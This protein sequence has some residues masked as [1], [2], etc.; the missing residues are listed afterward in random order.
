M[1]QNSIIL[2]SIIVV[3]LIGVPVLISKKFGMKPMELL[4]GKM[5]NRG[6]F[7]SKKD[8][9]QQSDK[10]KERKQTNSNRNDMLD[11]ISR[12]ATYARRNHFRLIIPGTLSCNGEM[13]VLTALIITRCGV[14]GI[15]CFGFGGRVVAEG[16][17]KD[18]VQIMNGTQTAFP[19]PVT[20]NR[21]QEAL[22]RRV[23]EA[24]GYP[25]AEVEVVGVFTSPSVWLSNTA[26][27]N[28]YTKEEAMKV[29]RGDAYLR[30][31]GLDPRAL[32]AVLQ[33][34]II[35]ASS[36]EETDS[37]AVEKGGKT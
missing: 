31:G 5:A 32:E 1:D 8:D 4:F 12:L 6:L 14:V 9:S 36:R 11:L 15:N 21:N 35:R 34:R 18:W 24:V 30:D 26:G 37:T 25:T 22:V 23:L 28:C 33:P 19:N 20:K 10:P 16:G 29:L 3:V 7:K 17:G 27:T 13:A 2:Y